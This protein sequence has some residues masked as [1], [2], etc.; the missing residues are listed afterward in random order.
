M[1]G[2]RFVAAAD[3]GKHSSLKEILPS[4]HLRSIQ[5][6]STMTSRMKP[7]VVPEFVELEVAVPA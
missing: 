3:T 4:R 1:L 5:I 2:E 7:E 6:G